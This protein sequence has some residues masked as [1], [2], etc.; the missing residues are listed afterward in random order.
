MIGNYM[1]EVK[2]VS[3]GRMD[4]PVL[5][6]I[7][8]V[9]RAGE[10][11]AITGASGSGKTTLGQALAGKLF[12]RGTIDMA[13]QVRDAV[14]WV[15]QQ[16]HFKNLSN[17]TD[18]YYQQRYNS[19][20]SEDTRT[21]GELLGGAE[22][23]QVLEIMQIAYLYDKPLIQL[24][25]GENKK[26]QIALALLR[27]PLVLIMDQPF[28][29][30]DTATRA[31]LDG[32]MSRLAASGITLIVIT[33]AGEIPACITGA[34]VLKEGSI[35]SICDRDSFL[36]SHAGTSQEDQKTIDY[37]FLKDLFARNQNP[38]AD[39]VIRMSKVNVQYGE[40]KILSDINWEVKTGQ[41]WLLS[42][43]NG[44]G[45][46]TL[47]SLI[48]ADNPQAYA[49]DI[50]L[51]GK[52]RGSGESIWDIK[53]KIGFLSSELHV[54]FDRGCTVFDTIASGL[55]DTI[56]LFRQL[57]ETDI[58]VVTAWIKACQVEHLSRRR[59]FELP[60]G[61]QRLV[62]LLR[63][64]VKDPPLLVLDE[65]CQGLDTG[66]QELLLKLINDVCV[67]GNKT[68]IFVT[69][70]ADDRPACIDHFIRLEQ[71]RVAAAGPI[72]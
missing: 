27:Q 42:G 59:L 25:S 70:Y 26:L 71:G 28:T 2:D 24:S 32:L 49:N 58:A 69:H 63:A 34:L 21:V 68:M 52:R 72:A 44:T 6:D 37:R 41:R 39:P 12:Y 45:K 29:G 18:L 56:G 46:S 1:I 66:Q 64:L 19:Y 22:A 4:E 47:L 11:L 35:E 50:C 57:S 67:Q 20:D 60:A 9:L 8:F 51:F 40:K 13:Q 38:V 10:H 33:G 17:T 15:E 36:K 65:P 62:L 30:L 5:K 23:D 3:V 53:R 7:S 55:F 31:Y 48:T 61:E 54:F 14:V 16:H 43:A